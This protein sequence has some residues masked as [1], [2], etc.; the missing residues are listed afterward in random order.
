MMP[1]GESIP[2]TNWAA[3]V[4]LG[5]AVVIVAVDITAVAT[6]LPVMA[7]AFNA[8]PAR[9]QWI[10]LAYSL[11]M[12]ALI[13]PAGRWVDGVNLRHAFILGAIGFALASALVAVAPTFEILLAGRAVQGAFG[14]VI[15]AMFLAVAA[16]VINPAERGQ[17]M[18]L[19]TT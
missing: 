2:R 6:G 7:A 13:L 4:A 19:I 1:Q 15:G 14:A 18:G 5:L 17:A 16:V 8:D 10:V 3:V 11:P 9:A 12:I